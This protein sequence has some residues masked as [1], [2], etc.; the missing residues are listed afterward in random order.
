MIDWGSCNTFHIENEDEILI[1]RCVTSTDERNRSTSWY[2]N[3]VTVRS[4]ARTT[5]GSWE[6]ETRQKRQTRRT[7]WALPKI[8]CG[9]AGSHLC[10]YKS[11]ISNQRNVESWIERGVR[12][13]V[14]YLA[15]K[16]FLANWGVIWTPGAP[17]VCR[18]QT[19]KPPKVICP[20]REGLN[21]DNPL[22]LHGWHGT[23][24]NTRQ[25]NCQKSRF[26]YAIHQLL[27]W[28][29]M[30]AVLG[31]CEIPVDAFRSK[32]AFQKSSCLNL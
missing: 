8:V 9:E 26:W 25:L 17:P 6:P 3:H 16:R 2:L 5:T 32:S 20:T 29:Y 13:S 19:R 10:H 4:C 15:D 31:W 21:F 27:D 7:K 23:L 14:Y 12:D 30:K 28:I 11:H 24:L 1:Y 18:N 22:I